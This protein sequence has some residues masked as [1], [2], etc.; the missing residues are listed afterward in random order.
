MKMR[1][2]PAFG[3]MTGLEKRGRLLRIKY[4]PMKRKIKPVYF[5]T[6]K[7]LS[8]TVTSE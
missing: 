8:L 7:C 6:L 1:N 2:N 3:F 5:T 4:S